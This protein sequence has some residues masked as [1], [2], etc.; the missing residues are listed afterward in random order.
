MPTIRVRKK[1][2][3]SKRFQAWIRKA[4]FAP[5]SRTFRSEREAV[6]WAVETETQLER[7]RYFDNVEAARHTLSEAI[8]RYVELEVPKKARKAPDAI[9][10]L[11]WWQHELGSQRLSDLRGSVLAGHR[12]RLLATPTARG[13]PRKPATVNRYLAALSHV[14]HRSPC[15]GVALGHGAEAQNAAH[16]GHRS[17]RTLAVNGNSAL[18]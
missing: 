13:K 7:G 11:R 5:V 18:P 9:S 15:Q 14:K 2:D 1:K 8:E 6:R 4:G 17:R 10:Q 12:D 16:F 3:G